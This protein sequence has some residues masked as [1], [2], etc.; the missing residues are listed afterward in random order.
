[1]LP[2]RKSIG[3]SENTERVQVEMERGA[4][5]NRVKISIER[6]DECLGWYPSGCLNLPL[7]QLPLLEQAVAEMRASEESKNFAQIIP[8]PGM[9][10]ADSLQAG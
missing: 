4:S 5:G 2:E 7:H 6:Y 8:F 1:M 10:K 3:S 9:E